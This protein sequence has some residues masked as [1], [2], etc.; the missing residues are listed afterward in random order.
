MRILILFL[1]ILT[2]CGTFH[3]DRFNKSSLNEKLL[4]VDRE[5]VMFSEILEHDSSQK[6]L[7]HIYAS[8]CPFSQKSLEEIALFQKENKEV[9]YIF[10]SVDHSYFDWK[11]GLDNIPVKGQHYYIPTKGN[12]GL[13]DFLKLKEIPRFLI[14]NENKEIKMFKSSKVSKIKELL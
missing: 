5:S 9:N 7:I 6:T 14:L 12:G 10:L 8:Y 4:S 11:R 3:P 1:F 2:G 13:G